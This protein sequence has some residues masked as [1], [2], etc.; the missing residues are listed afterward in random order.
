MMHG[1]A[2]VPCNAAAHDHALLS[3]PPACM[4][5]QIHVACVDSYL[6]VQQLQSV[7]SYRWEAV[8]QVCIIEAFMYES[9][10]LWVCLRGDSLEW[11]TPDACHT[12][13]CNTAHLMHLV[14]WHRL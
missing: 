11:W 6:H 8:T 2:D 10:L 7:L 13:H 1:Q 12:V 14:T 9:V 4:H 3:F 5:A